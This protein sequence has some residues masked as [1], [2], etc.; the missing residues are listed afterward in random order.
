MI[1]MRLKPVSKRHWK[2][3]LTRGLWIPRIII[4]RW[5]LTAPEGMKLVWHPTEDFLKIVPV[6]MKH[7][8]PDYQP[9]K[10]AWE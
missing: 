8:T 4:E 2:A 5:S 10:K 9:V 7:F 1:Q 6:W 3:R